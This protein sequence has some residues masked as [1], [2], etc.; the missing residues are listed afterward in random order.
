MSIEESRQNQPSLGPGC[1]LPW[2]HL[3]GSADGKVYPCCFSSSFQSDREDP[4]E[5]SNERSGSTPSA[6]LRS[7]FTTTEQSKVC[8]QDSRK[9]LE[10]SDST[11][12]SSDYFQ[13]IRRDFLDGKLPNY[14]ESCVKQEQRGGTSR[15]IE[16][17]EQFS[18]IVQSIKEGKDPSRNG[19]IHAQF[20]LGNQCNLKC[21]MCNPF[22][23]NQL[24]SE[25]QDLGLMQN[26]QEPS[27]FFESDAFWEAFFERNPHLQT[28]VLAGGETLLTPKAHWLMDY[29]ISKNRAGHIDLELHSNLTY[30]PDSILP[31]LRAFR[32]FKIMAS[33]DGYD[34]VNS[35]IRFPSKWSTVLEN[36]KKL[37]K[38]C[39]N[40]NGKFSVNV[41]VQ[42]YNVLYL[43]SLIRFAF[44]LENI[45][46]CKLNVLSD[47]PELQVLALPLALRRL[48]AGRIR[49]LL[50]SFPAFPKNWKAAKREAF[51]SNVRSLLP[52][53]EG[54]PDY[55]RLTEA[56]LL[57][58]HS[59]DQ[60]RK[61]SMKDYL[62]EL[63][64]FLNEEFRGSGLGQFGFSSTSAP[65]DFSLSP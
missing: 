8:F 46:Q 55:L 23:S 18:N 30:L 52:L 19:I 4:L 45:Y 43:N 32:S 39:G 21:R 28:L 65:R 11:D 25:W 58:T 13:N 49:E 12:F 56:W 20:S 14:C 9:R 36:I 60:Y 44:E 62:P 16:A 24:I 61:H 33:I 53:L 50:T 3:F 7:T 51:L 6:L 57:R 42:A 59:V 64:D 35:Y 26:Y 10:D 34:Q 37:D 31:K 1:I 54:S 41:T 40:S 22:S 17:I 2:V 38:W 29:L 63:A 48:A 15:R 27:K 47:P 5:V